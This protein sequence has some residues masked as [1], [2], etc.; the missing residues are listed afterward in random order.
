MMLVMLLE[1][2]KK[3][4]LYRKRKS[5]K[6]TRKMFNILKIFICKNKGSLFVSRV[7]KTKRD[8]Q[9]TEYYQT[10]GETIQKVYE[11]LK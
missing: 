9:N 6:E 8:T 2:M 7:C 4:R 1:K 5:L 10:E 3:F 11:I